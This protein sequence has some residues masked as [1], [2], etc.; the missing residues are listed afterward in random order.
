MS[1]ARARGIRGIDLPPRSFAQLLHDA[2]DR[3]PDK[4]ALV[5]AGRRWTYAELEREATRWALGLEALGV[6]RG[7]RI[8]SLM[9]NSLEFFALLFG[10]SLAGAT[11]VPY[12]MRYKADELAYILSD[13]T[14][15][16]VVTT[17]AV[18][19][20]V[21][22]PA[23][24]AESSA[25][26]QE[27]Y[28]V[29]GYAP[30]KVLVFDGGDSEHVV[31]GATFLATSD[32]R[33]PAAELSRLLVAS[34][35]EHSAI[36][37]TSGTTSRPKGAILTPTYFE[38]WA[39][40]GKYWQITE[41]DR[42][43]D[44]CPPF[45]IT[46]F[47]PICWTFAVGAT[48]ISDTYFEAGA[49]LRQIAEERA[50]LLYPTYPPIMK[51]LMTHPDFA[52]T[53]LSAVRAFVNIG[54]PEDLRAAQAAIPHAAQLSLYGSTEGGYVAIHSVD[55]PLEY[56]LSTNGRVVDHVDVRIF[57][58]DTGRPVAHGEVGEIQYRGPN[59]FSGYLGDPAKTAAMIDGEGWVHTG[60]LGRLEA[61]R[62]L[63]YLG[64][65][66][67]MIKVGGENVAPPEVE[68][69]LAAYPGVKLCQVVGIPD[70]R[71]SE[72]VAAFVEMMQG[73]EYDEAAMIEYCRE[74]MARFKVPVTIRQIDE[75]PMSATKI[76]RARLREMLIAEGDQ[77]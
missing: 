13:S 20:Y 42:F 31:G 19:D 34:I 67:E 68:E 74:R 41:Q 28:P 48:F 2:A 3:W 27:R 25:L 14:P 60:D 71:L 11:L 39:R 4:E 55:D 5:V 37:Y 69:V 47:G 45:H 21:D 24:L 7:A 66:N 77:S 76:Q 12:N 33:D 62:T 29:A 65:F 54:T 63:H 75:W 36:I 22:L 49:G 52:T 30:A 6:E 59:T 70:A 40:I 57:D 51:G 23:L 44:P 1:T 56:R 53:D 18:S 15:A 73:A 58:P 8:G 64:R 38:A 61:D 43:W 46:V 50:T 16:L 10:A 35:P 9:P 32:G 26:Q 17:E 72:V